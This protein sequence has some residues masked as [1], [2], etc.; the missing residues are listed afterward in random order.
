MSELRAPMKKQIR[1][2]SLKK[3]RR[4]VIPVRHTRLA[5][6]NDRLKPSSWPKEEPAGR[7]FILEKLMPG[8]RKAIRFAAAMARNN[9]EDLNRE[10]HFDRSSRSLYQSETLREMLSIVIPRGNRK[11][12]GK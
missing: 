7:V 1:V 6:E 9:Q 10:I 8:I 5:R 4:F 3:S 11:A 12:F 2:A